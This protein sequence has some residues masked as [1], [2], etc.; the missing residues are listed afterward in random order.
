MSTTNVST[1]EKVLNSTTSRE[2]DRTAA[3]AFARGI[4][5]TLGL[6]T[7]RRTRNTSR[8]T[9]SYSKLVLNEEYSSCII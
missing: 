7:T 1:L 3:N 5:G 2:V 4:L 8:K 6:N 9:K